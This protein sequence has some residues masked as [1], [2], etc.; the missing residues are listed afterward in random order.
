LLPVVV[1]AVVQPGPV[2]VVLEVFCMARQLEY[3]RAA[4]ME[5]GLAVEVRVHQVVGEAKVGVP[6]LTVEGLGVVVVEPRLAGAT[7]ALLPM[8]EMV[9]LEVGLVRRTL[10]GL[11]VDRSL[12]LLTPDLQGTHT[13][14]ATSSETEAEE[15]PKKARVV[16]EREAKVST[17]IC[18]LEDELAAR[19]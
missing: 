12:A 2:V 8:E 10:F 13:Q 9:G 3:L 18:I 11:W 15:T 17:R 5:F 1:A 19:A 14:E 4:H 16:V 7:Q 6:G